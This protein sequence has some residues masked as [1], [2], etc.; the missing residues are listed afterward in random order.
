[1]TLTVSINYWAVLAAAVAS[2][3]LGFLWYGPLFGK[4][5]IR[6]SGFSDK[7]IKQM[8]EK[9]QKGMTKTYTVMVISTL[10]TAY[11]LA[12]FVDYLQALTVGEA[13]TLGFWLWLGFLAT[14]QIGSVLWEQKPVK[15]YLIN[16][17]H[18]LVTLCVMAII[19]TV[20]A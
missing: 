4:Q 10:V 1:M 5:W 18:Y 11:V 16:T 12:H 17:L 8:K 7:Q 9:G 19:L 20:W 2:I 6:L 15:L 14:S 13:V 3:I